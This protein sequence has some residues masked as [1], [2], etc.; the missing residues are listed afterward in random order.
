VVNDYASEHVQLAVHN[1]EAVAAKIRHARHRF[2]GSMDLI[3]AINFAIGAPATLPTTGYA[4]RASGVTAHTFLN[5]IA[6]AKLTEAGFW[7]IAEAIEDL[8]ANEG[9]PAHRGSVTRRREIHNR[10]RA[11]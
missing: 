2:V 11:G 4:K 8:A 3:R 10:P 5:L 1:L 6:F 9:F 7:D